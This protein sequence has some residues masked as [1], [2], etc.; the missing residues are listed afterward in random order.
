[1]GCLLE[2]GFNQLILRDCKETTSLFINNRQDYMSFN[3]L[4]TL[5]STQHGTQED[6][7]R[8]LQIQCNSKYKKNHVATFSR[9]KVE[10]KYQEKNLSYW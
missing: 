8:A 9:I 1:M 5:D 4:D 3:I 2:T 10:L 7:V 6:A